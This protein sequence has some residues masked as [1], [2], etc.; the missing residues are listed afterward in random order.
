MSTHRPA[1]RVV[2]LDAGNRVLLLHWSDPVGGNLVWEPP[3]G[4]VDDGESFL[5]AA[6][7]ELAEETGLDP[8]AVQDRSVTVERDFRWRGKHYTG[9]EEFFLARF[10]E[11]G[12]ALGRAGL[13]PDEQEALLGHAW[14][15]PDELTDL[16]D[17]QPP[18]LAEIIR[19]LTTT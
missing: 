7:R 18:H 2:C 8:A 11:P 15:T 16:P 13:M 10:D 14:L 5:D 1:A 12:P 17:L 9:T 4:G 3:G 6:R 19:L